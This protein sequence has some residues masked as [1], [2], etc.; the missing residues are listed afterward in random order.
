MSL[1]RYNLGPLSE[2][3]F[4]HYEM[5]QQSGKKAF[6]NLMP[7]VKRSRSDDVQM[8]AFRAVTRWNSLCM[9]PYRV[10]TLNLEESYQR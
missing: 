6:A 4:S 5:I 1:S 8:R 9:A 10:E 3:S 7:A 2:K